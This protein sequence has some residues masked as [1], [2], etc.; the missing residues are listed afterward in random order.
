MSVNSLDIK[1]AYESSKGKTDSKSATTPSP[2]D[3][4][5]QYSRSGWFQTHYLEMPRLSSEFL[6]WVTR[7]DIPVKMGWTFAIWS[8]VECAIFVWRKIRT[9]GLSGTITR[10]RNLFHGTQSSNHTSSVLSTCSR[11][12]TRVS[13][14]GASAMGGNSAGMKHLLSGRDWSR[15][16]HLEGFSVAGNLYVGPVW[17]TFPYT[18]HSFSQGVFQPHPMPHFSPLRAYRH[19]RFGRLNPGNRSVAVLGSVE[20]HAHCFSFRM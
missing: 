11:S 6:I 13:G 15:T 17:H 10:R 1:A 12:E 18:V 8:C 16:M 19:Q 5:R 7:G 4:A 20:T 14:A 9:W 3:K 2:K